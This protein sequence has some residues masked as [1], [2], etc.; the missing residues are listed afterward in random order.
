MNAVGVEYYTIKKKTGGAA[1]A[2]LVNH[3]I[4]P[5]S[6]VNSSYICKQVS[7]NIAL[8]IARTTKLIEGW[9]ES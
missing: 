9:D 1:V 6:S 7:R 8:V 2:K 4:L 3:M 5:L